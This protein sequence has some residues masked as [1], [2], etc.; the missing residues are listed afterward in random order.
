[1]ALRAILLL[2]F[3]PSVSPLF[4]LSN[5]NDTSSLR[6][7]GGAALS[8][9]GA[10]APTFSYAPRV[11]ASDGHGGISTSSFDEAPGSRTVRTV[12]PFDG[13]AAANETRLLAGFGGRDAFGGAPLGAGCPVRL[14]L[15]PPRPFKAASVFRLEPVPVLDGWEAGFVL[16]LTEPSRQCTRVKDASFGTAS[17]AACTVA[18]GDG[19]AFVVHGDPTLASSALGEG[20]GG[21]GFAGLPRALAVEFDTWYNAGAASGD[22]PWDHVAVQAAPAGGAEF[23]EGRTRVTSGTDTRVSGAPLRV[24]LGD[25]KPHAVRV[26]YYATLRTEFLTRFVGAPPLLQ[27]LTAGAD[28]R[29]LGTLAVWVDEVDPAT[30]EAAGA[31]PGAAP[32][33]ALLPT[34]ALP[35]N[36]NEAL[37]LASDQAWVGLT[38]ATGSAAWQAHDVVSWYF[39]ERVGC[40]G[41]AGAA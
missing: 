15:T 14:R 11:G 30:G 3:L 5:F 22:V 38:A 7:N 17:H 35:L 40:A 29:P 21:L 27:H 8:A 28:R 4:F 13:P 16:Q 12:A 41:W 1:M 37:R 24:D 25:G 6:L 19:L 26:A 34:L 18:G 9:C 2:F 36:I 20:G 39:C 32:S 31:A 10:D 33:A 23:G